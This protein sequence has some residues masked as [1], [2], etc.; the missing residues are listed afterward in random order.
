MNNIF[1]F[2]SILIVSFLLYL[3]ITM[4][5]CSNVGF[6]QN[7]DEKWGRS[8]TTDEKIA[9][10]YKRGLTNWTNGKRTADKE[11]IDKAAADFTLLADNYDHKDSRDR[12]IEINKYL[13]DYLKDNLSDVEMAKKKNFVLTVAGSYNRILKFFPNNDEAL[14]YLSENKDEIDKRIKQS[15]D[16]GNAQLKSKDLA[17]ARTNFRTVLAVQPNNEIALKGLKEATKTE[18][19][20]VVKTETDKED[21]Y[22]KGLDAFESKDFLKAQKFFNSVNDSS[23]KDTSLYL[24]KAQN[25]IDALGL[26]DQ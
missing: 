8:Y 25:K 1:K 7:A 2:R 11:L 21:L 10:S 4:T 17:R 26:S 14:T 3:N 23:Y 13:D 20:A 9:L 12:L 22:K 15:L 19:V 5:G 6:F 18:K 24:E 16:A